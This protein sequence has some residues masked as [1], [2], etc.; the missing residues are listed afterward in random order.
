M[1]RIR[2]LRG[3]LTQTE[4]AEAIGVHQRNISYYEL[5]TKQP[6]IDILIRIADFFDVSIDYLVER[7]DEKTLFHSKTLQE[8]QAEESDPI[9][10]LLFEH[11]NALS[12]EAKKTIWQIIIMAAQ[13]SEEGKENLKNKLIDAGVADKI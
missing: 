4:L 12:R 5:G 9:N 6:P 13:M 10:E 3:K 1:K 2:E 11:Y 7:T 8:K